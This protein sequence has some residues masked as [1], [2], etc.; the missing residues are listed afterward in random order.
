MILAAKQAGLEDK[1]IRRLEACM[2]E[3]MDFVG[4]EEA[5]QYYQAY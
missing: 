3:Q 1:I 5:E 2:T 4:E